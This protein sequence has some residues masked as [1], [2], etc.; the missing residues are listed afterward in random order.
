MNYSFLISR[1]NNMIPLSFVIFLL[2]VICVNIPV[3][4]LTNEIVP[5]LNSPSSRDLQDDPI[6]NSF[7]KPE[8]NR[9]QFLDPELRSYLETNRIPEGIR[10]FKD[11][12]YFLMGAT[13]DV[14]FFALNKHMTVVQAAKINGG[15]IIQG[16]V[17]NSKALQRIYL[18]PDVGVV[19]AEKLA[20][21]K[22]EKPQ[23]VKQFD[24]QKVMSADRVNNVTGKGEFT[25]P[26][27]GKGVTIGL[28]DS[29][30]DF[31]V[32]DLSTAYAVDSSGYPTSFDGVGAG[33]AVT[34]ASIARDGNY[35]L[36]NNH[37]YPIWIG[38]VA[39]WL[40]SSY[41]FDTEDIRV[42]TGISS[43]S[44]TYKVGIAG[45]FSPGMPNA[46][47]FFLFLVTDS[48]V[49]GDYDTVYVDWET[50]WN[51]TA[52][53]NQ[54]EIGGPLADWDFTNNDPH[55]W[56]DGTEVL[57]TDFDKDGI[58]DFSLGCLANT[59]DIF[60][61]MTGGLVRGIDKTGAGIAF[62]CDPDGH[63]TSTAAAAASRGVSHY[64]VYGNGSVYKLPGIA[65][66]ADLMAIRAFNPYGWLWGTGWDPI[67]SQEPNLDF[68]NW[69]YTGNHKADLLTNSWGWVGF[70]I[71]DFVWGYDWWS[72]YIDYLSSWN[73]TLILMA[74]GNDGPGYGTGFTPNSA[75]AL[76][77]G[78][79]TSFHIFE[80]VYDS[81]GYWE[82]GT[83]QVI[84]WSSGGPMPSGVPKPNVVALGAYTFTVDALDHGQGNGLN[85]VGIFGGT[86][87]A[88]PVAAGVAALMLQ[89]G[90]D[91]GWFPNSD[92]AG[93]IKSVMESTAIDLGYDPFR[94]GAGRVD[95]WRAVNAMFG[96]ETDGTDPL[97]MIGSTSTFDRVATQDDRASG[98]LGYSTGL[99]EVGDP[100]SPEQDPSTRRQN[101]PS[102][103]GITMLDNSV[104]T[105][106]LFP[107]ESQVT[108]IDASV[109]MTS[110]T[111]DSVTAY[112]LIFWNEA[113]GVL[114]STS[115]NT[116]W[117]LEDHFDTVFMDQWNTCD[118]AVVFLTYPKKNF[119]DVYRS[120]DDSN[121]VFL[122]DWND[123]NGNG[124]IDFAPEADGE[125]RRVQSDTTNGNNHQLHVGKPGDAFY[126]TGLNG[127]GPTIYYRDVGYE[128]DKWDSLDV[129]VTVRLFQR[130]PWQG[131]PID[132]DVVLDSGVTW[133]VT[134]TV[135]DSATPGMYGGFLEWTKDDK[136]AGLTPMCVR[137]DGLAPPDLSLSWGGSDEHPYD[138][139]AVYGAVN[140]FG[141][142][143]I[144]GD[145]RF[146][147]VDIDYFLNNG[148]DD[149][150][151]WVMTNVTWTDPQTVIDVHVFMSGYG[152]SAYFGPYSATQSQSENFDNTGRTDGK[153][154]WKCQNVLLT[155]FTWD[156][157]GFWDWDKTNANDW[158]H[159]KSTASAG[160]LGYLGIALHTIEYG[161]MSAS[162][163]FIITVSSIRN[164]TLTSYREAGLQ[165]I[166]DSSDPSL[167]DGYPPAP[168][169]NVSHNA[170][171]GLMFNAP[172]ATI[173]AI[174]SNNAVV[175]SGSSWE[176]PH[177][178]FSGTFDSW[179][180]PGFPSLFIRDTKI[181][182]ELVN[183]IKLEGLLTEKTA[184]PRDLPSNPEDFDWLRPWP[185]LHAGQKI[186]L[187]L[188]I[189]DPP[190]TPGDPPH[191]L[192]LIL[193]SPTGSIV[194][195]ST[196]P[197]SIE[198]IEYVTTES[199]TYTIGVD[200]WGIDYEPYY[201]WG[202]WPGGLP[203]IVTGKASLGVSHRETGTTATVDSN[204]FGQ[205]DVF[206]IVVKGFTGTS[207]DWLPFTEYRV[208]DVTIINQF[209]PTVEVIY[210]NGG[211]TVGPDPVTITWDSSDPNVEDTL[212]YSVYVSN[213]SGETWER[214]VRNRREISSYE[215]DPIDEGFTPGSQYLVNVSVTD[216]LF[217]TSDISD[218]VFTF[219]DE[220]TTEKKSASFDLIG[221]ATAAVLVLWISKR[222][223]PYK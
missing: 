220:S 16:Y 58:N 68:L 54:L 183:S 180:L 6:P 81:N 162:E 102:D 172:T 48:T 197:G 93:H 29:G 114:H 192:E 148:T 185:N 67:V 95:A 46:L 190:G 38:D 115:E 62:M 59:N 30:T 181:M 13:P 211:E 153:P 212:L 155:D 149:F 11:R 196:E 85:A 202:D 141:Q 123:L 186:V 175:T 132:V 36:L 159:D 99:Y 63:G 26:I 118:Y 195:T 96:N 15:Y 207:L 18:R 56:G 204:G 1:K 22:T 61:I 101:H 158:Y 208:T 201:V 122:H 83:D 161:S 144:S 124:R 33:L 17:T 69:T 92:I 160:H 193:I 109:V 45:T 40:N 108:D 171:D 125:V 222:K 94:Q 219:T 103:L 189:P 127:K 199:G 179:S 138:N 10:S 198:H 182:V 177:A 90:V 187:D 42:G 75:G 47:E 164:S 156:V 73:S 194:A 168:Y 206:E 78:A 87:L 130:V 79:S 31:G 35:L 12:V 2:S 214:L 176:G 43:V 100:F 97:L 169:T 7:K 146:Y 5:F 157:S 210:P 14:D 215:W 151:T 191:D 41:L 116:T 8:F 174:N 70:E 110:T 112:E 120:V 72:W 152:S 216:G 139:G 119:E 200:Y 205:N 51:L 178:Q 129:L 88:C 84:T 154:T 71:Y 49:S 136:I 91:A 44:G 167:I 28:V 9:Y 76:T 143:P 19:M 111:A 166:D 173:R 134:V 20:N 89:A 52:I 121:Y 126:K 140:W 106:S 107:G 223:K 27:D 23:S 135:D 65:P 203:F 98:W 60:D 21:Y 150:T 86:S 74:A 137:V 25:Y 165:T 82:Q 113:T 217:K 4:I 80:D 77:V 128:N 104:F 105:G 131:T 170:L 66:A 55:K 145:W 34:N 32:T 184:I 57:A 53:Y 218:A 188:T 147:Y 221:F 39:A 213:D 133:D 209:S 50:S 3:L 37:S 142:T 64:D 24:M 117:P 163:D